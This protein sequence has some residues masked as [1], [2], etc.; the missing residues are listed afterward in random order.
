MRAYE[1]IEHSR[2]HQQPIFTIAN[3]LSVDESGI[4]NPLVILSYYVE[5]A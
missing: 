2:S 5:K 4:D 3:G 1:Y